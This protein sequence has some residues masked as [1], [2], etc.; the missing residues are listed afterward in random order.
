MNG[1]PKLY[2]ILQHQGIA[3]EYHEH[4]PAP[5]IEEAMKYWKDIEA[6]HC[7]NIFFR[8]HKGNRHYLV[9]LEHRQALDI[10][11]LEK[12]LKQGKLSFASDERMFRYLK[13]TPGSVTPFGLMNDEENH[14]HLFL[15][16]NLQDSKTIS[17]HPCIN[18]ASIIIK[19]EDFIRF[20]DW[21]GN[22][23]EFLDLY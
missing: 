6:T 8:N 18:T 17:F 7:K 13:L 5:T 10:H 21:S 4:P 2:S 22:S 14:V 12:R 1:D 20:L 15:D 3:F 23:Y 16:A 11:E 9:I 19:W